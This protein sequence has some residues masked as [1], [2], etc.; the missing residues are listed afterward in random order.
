LLPPT[1]RT[2]LL[3]ADGSVKT[4]IT[5]PTVEAMIAGDPSEAVRSGDIEK[6]L[7]QHFRV[8]EDKPWGG[9]LTFLIFGD[10]AGNFDAAN[11]YH[12]ALIDLLIHHENVLI[13]FG[14]LPSDFKLILAR[15][16]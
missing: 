12:R 3:K 10:I 8:I 15:H 6:I 7:G 9:T 4:Q 1:L 11:P 5:A 14:V 16:R 13:D 2:D